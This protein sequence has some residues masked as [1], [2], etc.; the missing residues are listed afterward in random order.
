MPQQGLDALFRPASIAVIGASHRDNGAGKLV[1]KNLLAGNFSG[2]VMPVNPKYEAVAG[3]M[4]YPDISSLPRIPDLAIIC[5]P[6]NKNAHIIEQL[7]QKGCKAAIILAAGTSNS[8]LE[9]MKASARQHRMRLLGPNSMGVILPHLGLN[10]SFAPFPAKPGRI[11][12]VS[13]SSAVCATI[14]DWARH[15]DIGFSHF[16]SL[17]DA[18]DINFAQ[19]LD[20]LSRDRHTSAI[21]LYMD[22]V[23]D[24]RAFMSAAR[25]ASRNKAVLVVKSGKTRIGAQLGHIHT[26]GHV[27]MD[28]AY[29]AAIRRAGMLRVRDTHDLFAAVETLNHSHTLRGE[30][31]VILTNGGGP[32]I[33]AIDTLLARG[34]KLASLTDTTSSALDRV[35]PPAWSRTNPI[36]IVGDAPVERYVASLRAL[37]DSDD[38]DAILIMHAPSAAVN[39][40]RVAKELIEVL[41]T[42]PRAKRFNILTNWSGETSA[43]EARRC[44]TEAGIPTYRTPESAAGAFMHMVEYRR[45]QKQLMETPESISDMPSDGETVR[46]LIG[47]AFEEGLH[48]LDTHEVSRLMAAYGIQVLPTWIAT[49]GTEAAHIAEQ[50]GYPVAIKL[51]S[52]DIVHKSEVSG[53]V[54]NLRSAAEVAQAADA[55]VDRVK[56]AY[57]SAR[58]HGLMVQR[59]ARR[60]GSQELHIAVRSDPVFGPVILLGD[61]GVDLEGEEQAAVALPPLNMTLARYLVIHALKSGKVRAN[62]SQHPMD[63][64]AVCQVLTQVSHLIINHP[65]IVSL[66]IHPLL[67]TGSELIALDVSLKLA[68]FEGDGQTRLAIRPYPREWEE[69]ALLKDGTPVTLRPILPEDEPAHKD[70][71]SHVTDE[72]RYKRFFADVVIGHEELAHM[73]QID[74]DREMAFVAVA[75]RGNILGVV[76]AVSDPDNDDAEFAVLVRSDLKGVGL[77]RMLMEKIIRYGQQR[78]L[79]SLSGITMPS[80]RGMIT[81]ARKLGFKTKTQLEDGIVEL[82]LLFSQEQ[83]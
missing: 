66:D 75:D 51:R 18:C 56:Q 10:V 34:G 24:A 39:S 69:R 80:N 5:T 61:G 57:P 36:D 28:A 54:L 32:A 72:D 42:H 38:F 60:A 82:K 27:G 29:D 65:E 25:A 50:I 22:A 37:L 70:F 35:L 17:G 23:Q 81:L 67:A 48:R 58:V 19:L 12:F 6:A 73:T 45:N 16:I 79:N 59:M 74:Y 71:V 68:P 47:Q 13:Q 52:P 64:M 63:M 31:L 44:F 14:L 8:Q 41:R 9:Q 53:V 33:N 76:R 40:T 2:P 49:D 15:N 26:G 4:A 83:Q 1:M 30:R 21:L 78:G 55:L 46:E 11:A 3:V 62:R 77:G 20:Y 7:G 43:F